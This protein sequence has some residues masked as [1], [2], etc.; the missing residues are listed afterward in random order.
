MITSWADLG[1]PRDEI[2]L[3][4]RNCLR[5]GTEFKRGLCPT[6]AGRAK[7]NNRDHRLTRK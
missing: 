1:V 2:I 3:A 7:S 5:E 4:C 6:C